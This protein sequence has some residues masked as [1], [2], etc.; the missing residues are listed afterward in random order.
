MFL[1]KVVFFSVWLCGNVGWVCVC[2]CALCAGLYMC[3]AVCVDLCGL[4][5]GVGECV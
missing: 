2:M 4:C 1:R 5:V 3:V